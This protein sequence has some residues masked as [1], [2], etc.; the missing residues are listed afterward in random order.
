ME[1]LE[2]ENAISIRTGKNWPI[3]KTLAEAGG[4]LSLIW[5]MFAV[6]VLFYS[7]ASREILP[8]FIAV[9]LLLLV[10][11]I[12]A[13]VV[14]QSRHYRTILFDGEKGV[15]SLSG[16][17]RSRQVPFDTIREFQVNRCRSKRGLFLYRL[18]VVLASGKVFRLIQDVPDRGVLRSLGEKVGNLVKKPVTVRA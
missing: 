9:T 2:K 6:L 1:V 4:V 3:P 7:Q 12:S 18:D 10:P 16:V 11:L 15:L 8:Y 13:I 14:S 17:W 5:G